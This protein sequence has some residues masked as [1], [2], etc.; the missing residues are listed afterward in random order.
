MS[1]CMAYEADTPPYVGSFST[2]DGKGRGTKR[3]RDR[4]KGTIGEW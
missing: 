3:G 1:A 4:A 2:E